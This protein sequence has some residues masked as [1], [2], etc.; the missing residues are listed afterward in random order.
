MGHVPDPRGEGIVA[1]EVNLESGEVHRRGLASPE[2]S[3]VNPSYLCTGLSEGIIYVAC[4][5]ED[6]EVRGIKYNKES[7]EFILINT[8]RAM[9]SGACHVHADHLTKQLLCANYE[10]GNLL[11]FPLNSSHEIG[12][13]KQD[14]HL[15]GTLG[16]RSDRQECSHPHQCVVLRDKYLLVPNLGFDCIQIFSF[17]KDGEVCN[18]S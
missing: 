10:G 9:G 7:D 4:E 13:A 2:I 8:S 1:F 16:P 17:R 6:S 14:L 3:G 15:K 18:P 11:S 12:P 5:T